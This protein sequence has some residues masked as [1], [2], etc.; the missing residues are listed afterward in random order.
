[1]GGKRN[2]GQQSRYLRAAA[3][4]ELAEHGF[5]YW[6]VEFHETGQFVC[7]VGLSR[8][9]YEAHFT[10][11]IGVGWR[12]ARQHWGKGYASEAAQMAL[13]YGFEE[14]R[15]SRSPPILGH[16]KRCGGWA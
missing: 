5:A 1:M 9:T 11:A 6:A 7:A 2:H 4:L 13:R 8:V 14:L 12:L 10:P 16:S 15:L 3:R